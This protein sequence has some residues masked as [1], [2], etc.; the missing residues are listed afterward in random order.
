MKLQAAPGFHLPQLDEVVPGVTAGEPEE[1]R[2][3]SVYFDTPDLR[4]VRWG[5]SLRHRAGEGWTLTLPGAARTFA[6]S[7]R[8][9]PP[10]AADLVRAYVRTAALGPVARLSTLRRRVPLRDGTGRA[11]AEVVDDEVSVLQGRRV[12]ARF[13][14]VEVEVDP[15]GDG[16]RDPLLWRL[17]VA[18][19]GLV[20][21]V[22]KVLRAL[23]PVSLEPPEVAPRPLPPA[24][25]A[26]DVV[27]NALAVSV[28]AVLRRDPG[29]R[30]GGGDPEDVHQARVGTRRLRSNLRT[31]RPLVEAEWADGLRAEL[32]W[33]GTELGAV[34][35]GE[36]LLERLQSHAGRLPQGD[37]RLGLALAGR[38]EGSIED[39]RKA[40]LAALRSQRYVDL[41]ERLVAAANQPRLTEAAQLPAAEVLPELARKPWRQLRNAVRALSEDPPDEELHAIRI[42]AK[43][44]R[45]AAEAVA[46]AA[47]RAAGRFARAAARLQ[48]VL[49]EH[50]D[51]VVAREWLR[52]HAGSGRRAFVAGEMAALE[53]TLAE[54]SRAAWPPAW[55]KLDK[56]KLRGWM[57]ASPH[58]TPRLPL[59]ALPPVARPQG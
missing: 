45:Y 11:L 40:L 4:L 28:A 33:L 41:L 12:A 3:E 58:P 46:P 27:T 34:R 22:P 39:A 29:I 31:F 17:R 47:G 55:R 23:G 13:R 15:G 16:V 14:E 21:P 18:G 6:G 42:R 44:A 2:L 56:K 59:A 19:A 8:T 36:V 43:R 9:P 24:P 7:S 54:Q 26:A 35:D 52:S 30:L 10:E 51:S 32:G 49:G 1:S 53:L 25:T 5:V 50:Q 38:L 20:E 48:T 37:R 57:Q